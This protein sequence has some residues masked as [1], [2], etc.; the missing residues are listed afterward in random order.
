[1]PLLTPT[2]FRE[3]VAGRRRGDAAD[4]L[5][6]L[7]RIGEFFYTTAVRWRNRRY[8]RHPAAA[9]HVGVPVVSVGNLTLGGTGKTPTVQWIAQWFQD[10][11]VAAAVVSRG[12]GATAGEKNDEALELRQML[13]DV[14]HVQNPNRVA[15]AREAI[16]AFGS[17]LIVL[18]DGFQHRRIARDLD[19]VLLDALEP[20]GFEHVFPRGMLREP[21]EGLRRADAVMLSRANL[22]DPARRNA[23]WQVVERYAP[24]AIRA[25]TVH[26]PRALISADGRQAPLDAIRGRRVAAFCGIGNPAGFRRTLEACGCEVAGFWE[27]P[28][29]HRYTPEDLS[30]LAAWSA[31][32]DISAIVC[33]CK[34]LVKLPMEQLGERPLWGV[35][36]QIAFLAGREALETRLAQ[37]TAATRGS[38]PASS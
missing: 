38:S 25:E 6:W 35:Q 27:F 34:D 24:K 26:A 18:D 17:R 4:L 8:D 2:A 23:I 22:L 33:T 10:R 15:A 1:M 7:L 19:I 13:P 29:H 28:D 5:R 3:I 30:H 11:G 12:Y 16:S 32:F 36:I 31:A 21:I 9:V 20:F 37:L 14:P